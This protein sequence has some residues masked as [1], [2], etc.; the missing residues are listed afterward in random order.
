[1]RLAYAA[2]DCH[3]SRICVIP[4]RGHRTAVE[5]NRTKRIGREVYRAAKLDVAVGYDLAMICYPG[6][7]SFVDR[8]SQFHTLLGKARLDMRATSPA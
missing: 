4:A 2:N 8:M 7:Y 6:A 1:M 5:R 3:Y